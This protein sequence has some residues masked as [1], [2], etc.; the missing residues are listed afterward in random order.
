MQKKLLIP[1][2][3]A[4]F[5]ELN[6]TAQIILELHKLGSDYIEIG[7][8]HS[9]ALADGPIIQSASA[10]ALENGLNIDI[11]FEQVSSIR[12]QI[13]TAK[14]I[15]FTYYNPLLVY[16]LAKALQKWKQ[17]GGM[18]LLVP[19]LPIE[20]TKEILEICKKENIKPSA[21][22]NIYFD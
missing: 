13:Q 17:A 8:P 12:E 5:P 1:F 9:D 15:L 10:V 19:D 18:G 21:L 6:S 2:F 20:E 14:L 22:P 4:G 3:S 7:L 16:G 11:L